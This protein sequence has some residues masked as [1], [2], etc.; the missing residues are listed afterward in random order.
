M[1]TEPRSHSEYTVGWLCAL[2]LEQTAATVMLDEQHNSELLGQ[3]NDNNAY[4]LGTISGHGV[5]ITCLPFGKIGTNHAAT[6][7]TQMI[8]TFPSI[9]VVLL[10]GIGGGIPPKVKLGDV[11][12]STPTDQYP[13]VVQWDFGKAEKEFKRT[14]ALNNPPTILLTA[15]TKLMTNHSLHGTKIPQ[16]LENLKTKWPNLGPEYTSNAHLRDPL[17]VPDNLRRENGESTKKRIKLDSTQRS[18]K[19]A[20]I[21]CGLIASGNQ[22]IKNADIRDSLNASLGGNLLCIEMEAAGLMA[23]DFPCIVIRG[24]CDYAD[25]QK[26]KDWQPYAATIA[27]AF[28]KELLESVKPSAVDRECPILDLL[29]QVRHDVAQVRSKLDKTEDLNILNWLS[30]IDYGVQ[31][32][33][34]LSRRQPGTG[35]WLLDTPEYQN[36]LVTLE[37]EE[38]ILFCPGMPGAGKTI[39]TS[40]VIDDLATRFCSSENLGPSLTRNEVGIAFVYCNFKRN[41]EQKAS[42][43]LASLLRQ[44]AQRQSSLPNS[45]KRLHDKFDR[46]NKRP[47]LDDLIE[48][49]Q[50]VAALY[51]K[52]FVIVDALDE[53]YCRAQLL[54]KLFQFHEASCANIFATS[55]FIPDITDIFNSKGAPTLEILAH[56]EDVQNYLDGQISQSERA[57]IR[58]NREYIKSSITKVVRGMFLLAQLH[59]ERVRSKTTLKELKKALKT[60][61]TGEA[62]YDSAYE[63]AMKRIGHQDSDSRELAYQVL[64]W[65]VRARRPLTI[66]ELQHAIAVEINESEFDEDNISEVADMVSV[67]VG[68]VTITEMGTPGTLVAIPEDNS[69][70]RLVHYT[71]Q[72]YFERTWESWF[73]DAENDLTT[74]CVT[75]LSYNTFENGPCPTD[76][77]FE[78]KLQSNI[79]YDYAAKNWG[80]HAY[81]SSIQTIPLILKFLES[82]TKLLAC[83]QAMITSTWDRDYSQ[84]FP[85]LSTGIHM[86]AYHGLCESME[87]V[88]SKCVNLEEIDDNYGK[89]PLL[90]ASGNGHEAVVRQLLYKGANL[91]AKGNDDSTPLLAAAWQGNKEVAELL[92]NKGANL[93]AKDNDDFTPLLRAAWQGHKEVAELLINK[94][95]NLEAKDDNDDFTPL[96]LA[97]WQGHKEM[98]ELL[99]NKGANLEAKD[100]GDLTP[101]L[102]AAWQGNKEVAELLINKG[103]NLEAKDNGDLTPLLLAVWQ[104]HKEVAEL[105]INKGANLEAKDKVD[106]TPLLRAALEGHKEVVELLINK[107]ASLEA[108]L[109]GRG[110]TILWWAAVDGDKDLVNL[111]VK[112][113]A[114]LEAESF[115]NGPTPIWWAAALGHKAVVELLTKSGAKLGVEGRWLSWDIGLMG[116]MH[117]AGRIFHGQMVDWLKEQG[118]DE[119]LARG[120]GQMI[121]R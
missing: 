19:D 111:L 92:I 96:L 16:L 42:D 25:S 95:A 40:V 60:L 12:V 62:A 113:G 23:V 17:L 63:D 71:T 115:E 10:V 29:G 41:D 57:L 4:T 8:T 121:E 82:K 15:L 110:P 32:N 50:S 27:A 31:Y 39:L 91:E 84:R 5:V 105:L 54:P 89:T 81:M 26:N 18:P 52:V 33:D 109:Y 93:E 102:A 1:A 76:K 2:P 47:S 35:Q 46:E 13:G 120:M 49:L 11:V 119:E 97:V 66:L 44:L 118:V 117:T 101:L 86:A 56:D 74:K 61:P 21:H 75:Y 36:W 65:I 85:K 30:P 73:P 70:I 28:A 3:S 20:K 37:K 58:A 59:F 24:I 88:L 107:S 104:G 51:S 43:L 87:V 90:I 116:N 80:R 68:L 108:R 9:K 55:R 34:F 14:G 77:C 45:V 100:N 103:A 64:S 78:S 112:K 79:L 94:D 99:I 7:A 106:F 69:V 72:E 98:A 38:R 114:N 83:R 53:C 6:V 48:S 22:V 67:C